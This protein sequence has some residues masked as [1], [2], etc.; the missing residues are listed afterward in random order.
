[1][2]ADQESSAEKDSGFE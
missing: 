1:L 2:G